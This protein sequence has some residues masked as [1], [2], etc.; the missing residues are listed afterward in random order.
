MN[1]LILTNS[2]GGMYAFRREIVAEIARKADVFLCMPDGLYIDYWESIGCTCIY[3]N[4]DR[5]GINAI[6][7]LKQ[8]RVYCDVI[9]QVNPDI[10]LTFTIKPNVYGGIA[11]RI[12]KIPY[13]SNVTGL[14]DAIENGGLL[15]RIAIELYRV[16][17]KSAACVFFQ[18]TCNRMFFEK[19]RLIS[20]KCRVIPGSGVNLTTF[21]YIPYP[22]REAIIHFL[23]VGRITKDKGIEELL[24]AISMLQESTNDFRV[25]ILGRCEDNYSEVLKVAERDNRIYYW[26]FQTDVKPF[27][28]NCHCV[29]LPSYHE[30]TSNVLLEAEASGRPVITTRVPGCQETFDEGVTGFGCEAKDATTLYNAMKKFM[31]LTMDERELMG[32]AARKKMSVQYDRKIVV[33]AYFE[34]IENVILKGDL[35]KH[36]SI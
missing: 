9:D 26:G 33:R 27:Y 23:F 30:G 19:N 12:K 16:G 14:G 35:E 24:S 15:G 1:V 6:H 21:K 13:L 22:K 36:E 10:C 32:I 3:N 11:C 5:H 34:E 31:E 18:N 8:I 25:D 20:G 17:I 7:E 4:F 29:V 2:S 28:Q